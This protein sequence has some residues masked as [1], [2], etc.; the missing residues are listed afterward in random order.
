MNVT[1][2]ISVRT[3]AQ[4]QKKSRKYFRVFHVMSLG[5]KRERERWDVWIKGVICMRDKDAFLKVRN[6]L[7]G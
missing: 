2:I 5:K 1:R 3:E 4:L 7:L 6:K